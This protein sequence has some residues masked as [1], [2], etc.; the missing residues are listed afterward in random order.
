[1]NP[2][3]TLNVEQPMTQDCILLSTTDLKGNIKYANDVFA[4]MSECSASELRGQSH[5]IVRHPDMP[6]AVFKS[7][8]SRIQAGKTW[9]GLV[10]NQTVTGKYYW[11]SAYVSPVYEKGQLHEFQSIRRKPTTEQVQAAE[12]LYS[13][14]SQSDHVAEL[15]KPLVSFAGKLSLWGSIVA[16]S[17]ALLTTVL[18]AALVAAVGAFIAGLG[19]YI[20]TKPLRELAVKA[21]AINDDPIARSIFCGR[22]DEIGQLDSALNYLIT[23]TG[24]VVGRMADSASSISEETGSLMQTIVDTHGRADSQNLQ[25][26][27]VAAAVE[28]MSASFVEVNDNTQQAAQEINSSL[29]AADL[30]HE[31]L[32]KVVTSIGE[33]REEVVQFSE[34][35]DSIEQD[36]HAIANVLSEIKGIAE[37]TNLLA[38]N[39]AI[40]AARAGETGRGFAV[41]ADEVRQLSIRTSES[42]AQISNIVTKFQ[43]STQT[44]ADAMEV[45]HKKADQS[46]ELAKNADS[47]FDQLRDSI[48]RIHEMSELN[49][50]AMNQQTAVATEISQAIVA[51]NDLSNVNLARTEEAQIKCDQMNRLANKTRLLSTQFW[52]QTINRNSRND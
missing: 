31:H 19:C 29:K 39:A 24:G 7:L 47:A 42:T 46:A 28:E 21:A 44:A 22:Q 49:A 40:E 51:I 48:G 26:N 13:K 3:T 25:T 45:S 18:P 34:V 50:V 36:S 37:Q 35:V 4:N 41:V 5:N 10:K 23:E 1:M 30:G 16:F 6:K 12:K 17:C 11:T 43:S 14:L 32:L 33:L 38:L 8:W 27:Q 52:Q 9:T 20:I 15:E 2:Q